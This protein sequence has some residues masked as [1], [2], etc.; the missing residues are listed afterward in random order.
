MNRVSEIAGLKNLGRQTEV[1]LNGIGIFTKADLE[2]IGSVRIFQLLKSEGRSVSL[3]LV[4]A[5]E[6][7]II[8][9]DRK[10]L[11]KELMTE[12]K[13]QIGK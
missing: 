7:A 5:I 11:P 4:Y 10:K 1:W 2:R 3:N 12:L 8:D 6:G 9:T 13:R